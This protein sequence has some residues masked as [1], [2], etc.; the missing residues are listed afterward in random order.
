MINNSLRELSIQ[1]TLN[2][3]SFVIHEQGR[4]VWSGSSLGHDLQTAIAA[5]P[6]LTAPFCAHWIVWHTNQ[7]VLFPAQVIDNEQHEDYL[8]LAGW[9]VECPLHSTHG[10]VGLVWNADKVTLGVLNHYFPMAQHI[11][12]LQQQ[13]D[14]EG[15]MVALCDNM[16]H[17]TLVEQGELKVAHSVELNSD[18][19]LLYY[20]Q[21]L[22]PNHCRLTLA[23]DKPSE[24]IVQMLSKYYTF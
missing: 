6:H 12:P 14:C 13:M 16:A 10:E 18:S 1:V 3:F 5:Y 24:D 2:G 19:D 7:V 22:T 4:Q 11:H 23:G 20:L 15:L 17:I 21:R 9:A 8:S